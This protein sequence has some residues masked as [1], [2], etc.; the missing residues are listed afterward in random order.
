MPGKTQLAV[1]PDVGSSRT[2]ALDASKSWA[3][4]GKIA[5][6]DWSFTDGTKASGAKIERTYAKPG[7]YSEIVKVTSPWDSSVTSGHLC[8][9]GRFGFAYVQSRKEDDPTRRRTGPSKRD[10]QETS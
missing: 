5:G 6:C 1:G 2:R 3:A 7:S 8:I 10:T 9:K 4:S